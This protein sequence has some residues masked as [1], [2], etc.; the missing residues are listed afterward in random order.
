M[1]GRQFGRHGRRQA[2][3]TPARVARAFRETERAAIAQVE[4]PPLPGRLRRR[5]G[6]AIEPDPVP[7]PE[8][9]SGDA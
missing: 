3:D 7:E 8:E 5:L 6:E 1:R 4:A 2:A 9:P